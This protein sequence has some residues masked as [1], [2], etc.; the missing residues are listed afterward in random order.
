MN[1]RQHPCITSNTCIVL[2][3]RRIVDVVAGAHLG[4]GNG[5]RNLSLSDL[6]GRHGRAR[7]SRTHGGRHGASLEGR[8]PAEKGKRDTE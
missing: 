2:P 5:R 3:K 4:K 6:H 7:N 1:C 8:R